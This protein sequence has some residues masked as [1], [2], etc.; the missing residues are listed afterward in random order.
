MVAASWAQA[1]LALSKVSLYWPSGERRWNTPT[2]VSRRERRG[3]AQ[4]HTSAGSAPSR[5]FQSG[6]LAMS[7]GFLGCHSPLTRHLKYLFLF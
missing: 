4:P 2:V 7:Q 5:D 1:S 3:T 6:G